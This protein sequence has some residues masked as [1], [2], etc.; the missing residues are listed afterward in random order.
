M[1]RRSSSLARI[2]A[3][4]PLSLRL[5]GPAH[6]QPV[7]LSDLPALPKVQEKKK[8]DPDGIVRVDATSHWKGWLAAHYPDRSKDWPGDAT[9]AFASVAAEKTW[10]FIE[11]GNIDG[12]GTPTALLIRLA[13]PSRPKDAVVSE[14]T[15]LKWRDGK[16]SAVLALDQDKGARMNRAPLPEMSSPD[17][18]GYFIDFGKGT[19]ITIFVEMASAKG[20]PMSDSARFSYRPK[21]GRYDVDD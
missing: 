3:L 19:Q 16:W 2:A 6:G 9:K 5:A 4:L 15:V 13:R 7:N 21:D 18:H 8:A 11:K 14:L 12:D 20:V 1:S 10:D 17:F